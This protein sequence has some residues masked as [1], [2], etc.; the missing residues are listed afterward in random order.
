M[1]PMVGGSAPR[2]LVVK[3][4]TH[5]NHCLRVAFSSGRDAVILDTGAFPMDWRGWQTLKVDVYREG[6][7]TTLHLRIT[8]SHSRRGW[9]W[10]MRILTGANTL[11]YHIPSLEDKVDLSAITE[12]MWCAEQPSGQ[13]Y[14]DNI[15]LSR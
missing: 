15:R 7:P 8:D 11:E 10:N 5:G 3:H 4:A 13:V 9:V 12:V 2:T 1:L 6:A 14:L